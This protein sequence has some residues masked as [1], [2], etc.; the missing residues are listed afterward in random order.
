MTEK[1]KRFL[2]RYS[3]IRFHAMDI[4]CAGFLGLVGFLLIFFHKTVDSWPQYVL[5]HAVLVFAILELVRV[6]EKHP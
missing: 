3:D 1:R 5:I 4:A 2:F 6:G